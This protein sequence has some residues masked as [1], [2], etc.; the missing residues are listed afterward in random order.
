VGC[1][2]A[3]GLTLAQCLRIKAN[4]YRSSDNRRDYEAGEIDAR[5]T[6]LESRKVNAG[7]AKAHRV[8]AMV[9]HRDVVMPPLPPTPEDEG[10]ECDYEEELEFMTMPNGF[11]RTLIPPRIMGF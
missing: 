8:A 10:L 11:S 3:A 1:K 6:A 5:I 7:T 9:S 2:S 4:Q